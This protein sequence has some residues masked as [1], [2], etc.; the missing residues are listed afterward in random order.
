MKG[1]YVR[2][3]HDLPSSRQREADIDSTLE[4]LSYIYCRQE[5]ILI[6]HKLLE[7]KRRELKKALVEKHPELHDYFAKQ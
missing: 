6:E 5:E 1:R 2:D 4:E 3:V 7:E